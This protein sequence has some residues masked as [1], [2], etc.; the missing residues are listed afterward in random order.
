[1]YFW[2]NPDLIH[3]QYRE[4]YMMGKM[5]TSDDAEIDASGPVYLFAIPVVG[6]DSGSSVF[7]KDGR[8]V[9]IVTYGI[10]GGQIMGGYPLEFT[11]EQVLQAEGKGTVV[12]APDTRP[13][14]TVPPVAPT[15]LVP[16]SSSGDY[17]F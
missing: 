3:D 12:I 7:S 4:G 8:L 5:P 15:T 6:G 10:D 11:T 9:M 1:V 16:P 17:T 2:G 14:I 13:I